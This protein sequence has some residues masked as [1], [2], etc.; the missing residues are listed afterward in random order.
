MTT[1]APTQHRFTHPTAMVAAVATAV[2]LGGAAAVGFAVSLD[3][4]DAPSGSGTTTS[5]HH[6]QQCPDAR[7]LPPA[8]RPHGNQG[9]ALTLPS[10][11]GKTMPWLP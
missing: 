9:S 11:G 5:T 2:I 7:C 4:S 10:G 3:S 1:V 6:N 8:Q